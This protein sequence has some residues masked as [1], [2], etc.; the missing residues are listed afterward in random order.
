MLIFAYYCGMLDQSYTDR[1]IP[2]VERMCC[3]LDCGQFQVGCHDPP[4]DPFNVGTAQRF[5][6]PFYHITMPPV[7]YMI[8]QVFFECVFVL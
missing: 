3:L 2:Q 4:R 5:R 8:E 6:I 1:D 7:P